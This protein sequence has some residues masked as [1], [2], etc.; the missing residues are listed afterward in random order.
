MSTISFTTRFFLVTL[1][2]VGAVLLATPEAQ[3]IPNGEPDLPVAFGEDGV[4]A[5][6]LAERLSADIAAGVLS[7]D[8]AAIYA[9]LALF[10]PEQL[11][12]SYKSL[13][14]DVPYC[15]TGMVRAAKDAATRVDPELSAAFAA[16]LPQPC[17]EPFAYSIRSSVYPL[18]VHYDE[19]ELATAAADVLRFAEEQW[20][21]QVLTMGQTAPLLDGG[22][23]GPDE[24]I[25]LYL[26]PDGPWSYVDAAASN[27]ATFYDDWSDFMVLRM[28]RE[29]GYVPEALVVHEFQHL[30]QD[31]DDR[32]ELDLYEAAA[33]FMEDVAVG[34]RSL[35]FED[36]QSF[37]SRPY[38][39]LEFSDNYETL[40][41]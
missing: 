39:P 10:A 35:H 1:T 22:A 37:A 6:K 40:F 24:N 5:Q 13:P 25:D 38:L 9:F 27:P 36:L 41:L 19:A 20:D 11:P 23:C 15:G 14:V 12:P 4:P 7:R 8:E 26:I 28:N 3:A 17:S 32:F 21:L 31:A 30:L 16:A 2:F 34:A 18:I 29:R 33:R